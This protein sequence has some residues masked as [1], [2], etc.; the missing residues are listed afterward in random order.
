MADILSEATKPGAAQVIHSRTARSFDEGQR[1]AQLENQNRIVFDGTTK[2]ERGQQMAYAYENAW[3]QQLH[4][5]FAFHM[6][7]FGRLN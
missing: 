5:G 7:E 1:S 3:L 6:C 2:S 4:G